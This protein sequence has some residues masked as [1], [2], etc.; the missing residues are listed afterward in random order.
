MAA[1]CRGSSGVACWPAVVVVEMAAGRR[2]S[3]AAF[4]PWLGGGG[5][6]GVNLQ[7]VSDGGGGWRRL[8]RRCADGAHRRL[9]IT[10]GL[11]EE[12]GRG[13]RSNIGRRDDLVMGCGG[14]QRRRQR[15][16]CRSREGRR[17]RAGSLARAAYGA[18]SGTRASGGGMRMRKVM[19]KIRCREK[20]EWQP[21]I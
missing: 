13:R 18:A 1:G 21:L 16:R 11:E 20:I 5:G 15:G 17:R 4:D 9:G 7:L 3:W 2:L 8:Q 19:G 14:G 6:K 12:D 10:D